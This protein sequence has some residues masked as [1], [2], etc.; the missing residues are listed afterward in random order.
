M[1]FFHVSEYIVRFILV[2]YPA[3]SCNVPQL[4]TIEATSLT[5][6]ASPFIIIYIVVAYRCEQCTHIGIL[7]SQ[8]AF[9]DSLIL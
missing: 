3:I 6:F 7:V 1:L 5:L 9:T 4:T 8:K 2:F